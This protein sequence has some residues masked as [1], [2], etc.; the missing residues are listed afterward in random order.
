[1]MTADQVEALRLQLEAEST[2]KPE[3]VRQLALA[4]L[5]WPYVFGAWGEICTPGTRRKRARSDHPTVVSKCQVLSGKA[6]SC[7]GCQWGE[8]VRMFDCRGFTAW[9]LKQVGISISGQ[10]ATSQY[11]TAA[12]WVQRG[13]IDQLPDCVCCLFKQNG[14]SMEHTGM[15]IGGGTIIHC[16]AG[17]Q[18]GKTSDR[19]W[20]HYAIPAGL[21]GEGEIPVNTVSPTLRRGDRGTAVV[22]M[23]EI[24]TMCGYKLGAV[25][26]VF[27]TQ[28]FNALV[29]FQTDAGLNPDGICGK[30]TWA[31]LDVAEAQAPMAPDGVEP[32]SPQAT[33]T[34]RVT[35]EGVTLAQY[36]QILQICPLAECYKE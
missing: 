33:E 27:G 8:G 23:Q 16:S 22:E 4:C 36:K 20:T 5:G 12:N 25:D 6:G 28:T 31:A 2:P 3:T 11:N 10:G 34:Y 14:K 19:G 1:M 13:S 24:L 32:F 29:A 26:G 15:H 35:I 30:K 7:H 21:Y 9:L 17:V 18:T